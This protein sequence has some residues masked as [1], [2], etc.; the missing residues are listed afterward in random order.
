MAL[1][2]IQ[3]TNPERRNLVVLSLAI[4]IF[5]LA[6]G[7][8]VGDDLRFL[9]ANIKFNKPDVIAIFIWAALGWFFL[10]YWQVNRGKYLQEHMQEIKGLAN[11]WLGIKGARLN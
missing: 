1:Q 10:R 4:I 3:D 11:N 5:Y 8:V 6:D 9:I 7:S 2:H